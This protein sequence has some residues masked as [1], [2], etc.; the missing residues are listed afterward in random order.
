M[1]GDSYRTWPSL[2]QSSRQASA[3]PRGIRTKVLCNNDF[4]RKLKANERSFQQVK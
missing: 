1:K 3:A 4:S 2:A